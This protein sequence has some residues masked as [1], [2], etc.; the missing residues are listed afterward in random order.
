MSSRRPIPQIWPTHRCQPHPKPAT[1]QL[2]GQRLPRT[3][4]CCN[5][6]FMPEPIGIAR[7]TITIPLRH[8]IEMLAACPSKSVTHSNDPHSFTNCFAGQLVLHATEKD[9]TVDQYNMLVASDWRYSFHKGLPHRLDASRGKWS[10]LN[11]GRAST[12]LDKLER[13][14]EGGKDSEDVE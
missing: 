8:V 9:M 2:R 13:K 6:G 14:A 7:L 4:D 5:A 10:F 12:V 3:L 1:G 11:C